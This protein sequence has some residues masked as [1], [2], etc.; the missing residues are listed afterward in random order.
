MIK[1]AFN[2]AGA[3]NPEVEGFSSAFMDKL[4]ELREACAC[5]TSAPRQAETNPLGVR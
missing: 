1:D 4:S 3:E 5:S 2:A